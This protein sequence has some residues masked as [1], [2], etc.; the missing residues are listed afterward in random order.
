MKPVT[1]W[2]RSSLKARVLPYLDD[3]L[4]A[5]GQNR[6]DATVERTKALTIQVDGHLKSLGLVRHPGK[7]FWYPGGTTRI[8]HLGVVMD[9]V[10]LRFYIT[11]AK[12]E[13]IRIV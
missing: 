10:E 7:G 3:Y 5:A 9:T 12:L 13:D 11:A 2:I 1:R 4:L 6:G 8:E